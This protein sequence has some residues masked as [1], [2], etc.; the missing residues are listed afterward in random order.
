MLLLL[1]LRLLLLAMT[2][3]DLHHDGNAQVRSLKHA[4]HNF[5]QK[6][7]RIISRSSSRTLWQGREGKDGAKDDDDDGDE[8][9]ERDGTAVFATV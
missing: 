2:L 8:E 9:R 7:V 5:Q 1:P 3:I 6:A 4:P